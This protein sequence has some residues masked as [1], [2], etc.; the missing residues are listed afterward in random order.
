MKK[1][2]AGR[3]NQPLDYN[4]WNQRKN[5]TEYSYADNPEAYS[6]HPG[7]NSGSSAAGA[8]QFLERFY[9]ES[10]F[11]PQNQDKAAVNNMTSSSYRAATAGDM[12]TFKTTTQGRWTS[13]EHWTTE[14]LKKAF[15]SYI[16]QE[17][18]GNSKV[19]TPVGQLLRK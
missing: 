9:K 14:E 1:A 10:N 18:S 15:K 8:Y 3:Q 16:T 6:K 17:L 4:S 11:S 19:A 12:E 13:L 5:F 7:T 2:E